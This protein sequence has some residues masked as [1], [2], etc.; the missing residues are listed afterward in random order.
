[1]R[2]HRVVQ[3]LHPS[4]LGDSFFRKLKTAAAHVP[5]TGK[6]CSA[7]FQSP[8]QHSVTH[9][10]LFLFFW[11]HTLTLT[12][13]SSLE[14]SGRVGFRN[15]VIQYFC[16]A[17]LRAHAGRSIGACPFGS[18]RLKGREENSPQPVIASR[19]GEVAPSGPR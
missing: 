12:L 3:Q 9:T 19:K 10:P 6:T 5:H 17:S 1:M 7:H 11:L 8:S 16:K 4:Q 15:L 13:V 18:K 14:H 2:S